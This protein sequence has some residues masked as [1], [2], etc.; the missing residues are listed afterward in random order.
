MS[1]SALASDVRR[2]PSRAT[3]EQRSKVV[4]TQNQLQKRVDAFELK[5]AGFMPDLS[6]TNSEDAQNIDDSI[7]DAI[8][9][10]S[11]PLPG[12]VYSD[13]NAIPPEKQV[14]SLPSSL[15]NP[16]RNPAL[17]PLVAQELQLRIGQANDNLRALRLAIAHKSFL[18]RK[19]RHTQGYKN[20]TRSSS[21]IRTLSVSV[22]QAARCYCRAR[23]AMVVLGASEE[24]LERFRVLTREDCQANT[25]VIDPNERGHRHDTLSW[26]W[27]VNHGDDSDVNWMRECKL[28][29]F[30][31]GPVLMD[32]HSL[33]CE[34][35]PR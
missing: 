14:L 28:Y 9:V 10:Y 15:Q 1:R 17:A 24:V 33:S 27:K 26:I 3:P 19:R 20:V 30:R 32:G 4:N 7:W 23:R 11:D 2:L 13:E 29:L 18:W 22:E 34:L 8:D 12:N 6:E 5:A 31:A 25:T 35:P 16:T 21:D